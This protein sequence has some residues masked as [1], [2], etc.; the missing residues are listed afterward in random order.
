MS[1]AASQTITEVGCGLKDL[2]LLPQL[3]QKFY[4]ILLQSCIENDMCFPL[5]L[6]CDLVCC[7][8]WLTVDIEEFMNIQSV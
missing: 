1:L 8:F 5:Q 2:L 7:Q 3:S 6:P 4:G